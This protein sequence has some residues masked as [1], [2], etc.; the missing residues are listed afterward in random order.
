MEINDRKFDSSNEVK[1]F[2]QYVPFRMFLRAWINL[3][4]R[5]KTRSYEAKFDL[6][7]IASC[8][9][10]DKIYGVCSFATCGTDDSV[11]DTNVQVV[12]FGQSLEK[13]KKM[14]AIT[15]KDWKSE[16]HGDT[17]AFESAVNIDSGVP[18]TIEHHKVLFN[19]IRFQR[20]LAHYCTENNSIASPRQKKL[21][22][23]AHDRLNAFI[24]VQEAKMVEAFNLVR[25]FI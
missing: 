2:F 23:S 9:S 4:R 25:K 12:D 16:G 10:G 8:S 5:S 18:I 1:A 13:Q 24:R 15:I 3:D 20:E 19:L 14:T 7:T 22:L 17:Y 11:H 21:A 6:A